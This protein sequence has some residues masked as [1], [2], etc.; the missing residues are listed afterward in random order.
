VT[1]ECVDGCIEHPP[2]ERRDRLDLAEFDR[3]RRTG[4]LA[5]APR[6]LLRLVADAFEIVH[7]VDDRDDLAQVD[8]NRLATRDRA[9]T[10]QV[11]LDLQPVHLLLVEQHRRQERFVGCAQ[12][13]DRAH[14]LAF[15]QARHRR[16]GA[17]QDLDVRVELA[18]QV[19]AARHGCSAGA[20]QPKRP[21]M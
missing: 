12:G 7:D 6:D 5:A 1:H 13:V 15:D 3:R 20:P 14:E 4:E 2:D 9:M 11:G 8:R 18:M 21:V 17:A 16:H 19:F 10:A